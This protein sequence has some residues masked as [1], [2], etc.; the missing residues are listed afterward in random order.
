M[1]SK[2]FFTIEIPIEAIVKFKSYNKML[3]W[4]S[5]FYGYYKGLPFRKTKGILY[6]GQIRPTKLGLKVYF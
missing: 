2:F 3:S 5:V 4:L 6:V 1:K